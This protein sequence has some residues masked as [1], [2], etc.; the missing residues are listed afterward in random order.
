MFHLTQQEKF[1]I[2]CLKQI[3]KNHDKHPLSPEDMLL[4]CEFSEHPKTKEIKIDH[5]NQ[6]EI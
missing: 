1:H 5:M 6:K 3:T 4:G 2:I